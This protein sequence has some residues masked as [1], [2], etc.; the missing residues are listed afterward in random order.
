MPHQLISAWVASTAA[1]TERRLHSLTSVAA[2]VEQQTFD[3]ALPWKTD[4][5]WLAA[6][7]VEAAGAQQV[8]AKEA[9][10]VVSSATMA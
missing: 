8:P 7:V 6:V 9:T 2:V 10:V 5:W 4:W 3:V 1:V